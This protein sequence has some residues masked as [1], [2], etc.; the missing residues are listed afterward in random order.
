MVIQYK[1]ANQK[2]NNSS[3]F[4][5][6]KLEYIGHIHNSEETQQILKFYYDDVIFDDD[7]S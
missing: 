6:S 5:D 3:F 1:Y 7:P 4:N 2:I